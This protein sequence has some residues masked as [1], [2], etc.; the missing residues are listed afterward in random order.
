MKLLAILIVIGMQ[1]YLDV[2]ATWPRTN[3]FN[4]YLTRMQ[5]LLQRTVLWSNVAGVII[6]LLPILFV[7]GLLQ[8]FFHSWS[9]FGIWKL[10]YDTVILW[11][12]LDA[13]QLKHQLSDYFS[14][15]VK[16]DHAISHEH[17]TKFVREQAAQKLTGNITSLARSI[18][19]E[20]FLRSNEQLFG[21][22]FW[23]VILGP[24]GAVA[25]YLALTLRDLSAKQNSPFVE[26]LLPASKVYGVL[27]WIPV[28]ILGLS[29]ALVGHFI[30]TFNYFRKNLS[31]GIVQTP[32][33][34]IYSGFSALGIEHVDVIHADAEEN[35]AAL[36]LVDRTVFLWIVIVAIFT[37]GGLV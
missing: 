31:A 2:G 6:I 16:N 19:C 32:E 23:F 25:Y 4:F 37:L 3:W 21:V 28:R 30:N 20:I 10:I 11:F 1:R 8:M 9:F 36:A 22:L 18:T 7:V 14:A 26:L 29:Y 17:G 34:A 13:Y 24:L 35:Q 5:S 27:D 12:C 15:F 33:F